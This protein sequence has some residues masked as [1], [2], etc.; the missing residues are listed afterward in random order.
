M[1][2]DIHSH[3]LP[4]FSY[5]KEIIPEEYLKFC[6]QIRKADGNYFLY[7]NNKRITKASDNMF[8]ITLRL[9]DMLK[10]NIH[11]SYAVDSFIFFCA[12]MLLGKT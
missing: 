4:E 5:F 10:N 3:I 11:R 9:D 7:V 1:N 8:S 12:L 2:I 6:P